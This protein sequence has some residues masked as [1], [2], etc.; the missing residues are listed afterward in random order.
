CPASASGPVRLGVLGAGLFASQ[1]LLPAVQK[2]GDVELLGVCTATGGTGRH[3]ATRFGFRYC[4]TDETEILRDT[5]VNTVLVATRHHLHAAQVIA[6]L[7][8]GKHVFCE[9]PLC[10]TEQELR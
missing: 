4:T 9:K 3:A 5:S 7:E 6:A 1:V 8:A 10:L 2:A